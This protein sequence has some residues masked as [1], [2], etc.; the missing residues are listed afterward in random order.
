M[1]LLRCAA[2]LAVVLGGLCHEAQ[3]QTAFLY[4]QN[5]S[6]QFVPVSSTNPCPVS[7]TFS[8]TLSGFTPNGSYSSPLSVST[9]SANV[10]VPTGTVVIVSNTGSATAYVNLGTS[11]AVTA[12]T[13]GLPIPGG[14]SVSVTVGSNTYLAAI[15]S[16]STTT[17]NLAGGTGLFT[18]FGGGGSSGGGGAITAASGSY[19]SGALAAGSV[20]DIGTGG[21]PA[22]NTVNSRLATINTTLGSPFQAG[23]SIANTSFAAT[24]ATAASLNAT[25]VGTGT[26]AV[27]A[28][29]SGTWNV[30]N[31]SGT[32]SLPTGAATSGNQTTEITSLGTI[33]G[34]VTGTVMQ[35][36]IKQVNG[37]TTLAGAGAVGTGSIRVAVGQDTT[38][39]AGSAPGTAG[40]ASANVVTVQGVASMTPVQ[41]SQAT[42]SNLNATVNQATGTNLHVVCDS[43]CS[44]SSAPADEA[45]FTFGTTSQT[46][47]GGVFQTTATSNPLTTGQM[48]A[49]QV[50]ANRA[51][52]INLR[53]AAGA[54]EGTSGSPLQ[55]TGANGTFPASESGTW[56]VQP[57]NTANTTAWLV[58]GTG[59]TFPATESGTWNIT[60]VSGTVSLP[61]GASTAANQTSVIGTVAAGTAASNALL[62]GAVYN[63]T[64]I[65]LSTGQ[66]SSLQ[67]D[68]NGYLN[69]DIKAG[70]TVAQASTTSGQGGS[71]IMGAVT[72]GNPS[73]T[74]AQTDPISLDTAGGTRIAGEGSAGTA[75]GGVL[76]VQGVA[77]MTPIQTS[78]APATSGGLSVFSAIAA[79][80]TTSVAAK[81]GAGQLYGIDAYSISAATP[82]FIK[83]YNTA[84]GS[85]TCGSGTPVA[86]YMIPASGG[87]AGS[88]Q[89]WHDENGIAFS[90]AITYCITA[91][92]ADADT[93]A[94]AASTYI[95]NLVYK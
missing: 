16:S 67:S 23:G 46:P 10:A 28:A 35:D 25:V 27:Q 9:S 48:G 91:G 64:P 72:T 56:T 71:L 74:T 78:Q 17:L 75:T 82:V 20:V 54:E 29:Q 14:S 32:V 50:T 7:G 40:S 83:L 76:T 61:T 2:A 41:V 63:S 92:I 11:N 81:A 38:T 55:V 13:S 57:G 77:S 39:I 89:I 70:G 5:S 24:Q 59:G 84:Q 1:N 15:T 34:A 30:T 69:V 51:L 47:I 93:T 80:N 62:T 53:S 73:Y 12:T 26:F 42:A 3:A 90:T 85:T 94:P 44:S 60:N 66:Q 79:N 52:F 58:T 19:S 4:C 95:V 45:A 87:A 49:F 8:T 22:A 18:G 31:I 65:T 88:G 68:G 6:G 43:G 33:A 36:N 86:R 37:V 21:S